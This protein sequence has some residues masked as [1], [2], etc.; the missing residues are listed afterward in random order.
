MNNTWARR[1]GQTSAL[2][3]GALLVAGTGAAHADTAHTHDNYGAGNGNQVVAPIQAPINVCGNAVSLLGVANAACEGG[4]SAKNSGGTAD[5]NTHDSYGLLNGNQ[6]YAPV[7]APVDVSGNAAAAG[8]ASNAA[9]SGGSSATLEESGQVE[10]SLNT[11]DNYGL[12]NGNQAEIPVQ[13]PIDACGNAVAVGGASNAGCEG[14][15][16]A[17][18]TGG[19]AELHSQDNYGAGNGNQLFAPIQVPVNVC[20]NSIAV[21]G[22]ANAACEGGSS[23]EITPPEKGG[24]GGHW[25]KKGGDYAWDTHADADADDAQMM[26]DAQVMDDAV[27]DD[28]QLTAAD[29]AQVE[30][31]LPLVGDLTGGLLGGDQDMVQPDF[32]PSDQVAGEENLPLVGNLL[33]S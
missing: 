4:A 32:V 25:D 23:A 7:Q 31:N 11:H 2:A 14:G 20:G 30:E 17:K 19:S 9:S 1:A 15:S 3:A 26:D 8:G 13:V 27:A 33:G 12:L 18:Y 6:A 16:S 28:A 24:K 5:L 21:L 10:E 22:V 29:D